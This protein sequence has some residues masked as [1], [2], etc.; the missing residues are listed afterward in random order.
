MLTTTSG[1]RLLG[2]GD[3]RQ[4]QELLERDPVTNVFVDHR[5]RLTRLDPR[6][7]GGEMWG[8]LDR[9]ELVSLCHSAANLVPVTVSPAGHDNA[10]LEAFVT[11]AVA[12]GRQCSSI[13]GRADAVHQLWEG[14]QPYWGRPRL[15]RPA[16]PFLTLDHAP[17]A[18]AD[19]LVRRVRDDEFEIIYPACVQMF[20]EEVGISP[21]IGGGRDLYRARVR[22]MI[23]KGHAFARIEDGE[24]MFK[25][26]VGSVTPHAC[27]VQGVW[28]PP[29]RRGE[30]LSAAGMAA[31]VEQALADIAPVVTLYVNDHNVAARRAYERIG[32]VQRCTFSTILF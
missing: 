26:E 30:G 19:P 29:A 7:L 4:V 2:P 8:Y 21:E 1:L 31:V 10:A 20:I 32:M 11:R 22:Q 16:Q 25:A 3:L 27:Q 15:V 17:R 28:V 23:A 14:V 13:V 5:V 9:G 6:W 12:K 24:V 18:A